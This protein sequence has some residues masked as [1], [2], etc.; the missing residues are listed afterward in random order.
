MITVH[1]SR[2]M[3]V[4]LVAG[5]TIF[6][7]GA[8]LFVYRY[9]TNPIT[10]SVAVGSFN[11]EA[12]RLMTT[13]ASRLASTHAHIRLK[14]IDTGAPL[15]ATEAFASAKTDLAVVRSDTG[16]LSSART[17]LLL[18]YGVAMV[19]VPPGSA[20][21]SIDDL[22]DTTV[23]V[24]GGEI[25]HDL[26]QL[27][28][29]IY[30]LDRA[31]VRFKDLAVPDVQ[32]AVRLKQVNALLVVV[33]MTEQYLAIVRNFFERNPKRKPGLIPI[34]SAEAIANLARAYESFDI[35][36]GTLQGSPP[37][38]DD[39]MT[40]LRVA[41]YLVANKKLSDRVV[42]ELA[43][44]TMEARRDMLGEFP[45]LAQIGAPSTDKD[46]LIPIHPG[47]AAY[48]E[49]T[50]ENLLD[51][52]SN[53]LYLIPMAFG[54]LASVVAAMWKFMEAGENKKIE[55]PLDR[56]YSLARLIRDA[57]SETD[58]TLVEEKID[59]ILEQELARYSK[60]GFEAGDAAALSLAAHRLEHL[61]THRRST[62][63]PSVVELK[64]AKTA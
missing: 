44:V 3:R 27:L 34:E 18:T 36:K 54:A 46:A 64:S 51:T 52:Y 62:F 13:V 15:G 1:L 47:A 56:L 50:E 28:T 43:K 5:M 45:A 17:V 33:P 14:I 42:S 63:A 25:N 60:G 55:T 23:G 9:V 24:V 61:I 39:D 7:V 26:V 29:K 16:D 6:V 20:I 58:V 32:Q 30:D 35:P 10:L 53:A 21:K 4:A 48:F 41:Y 49:G 38:P 57:R 59:N 31:K 40:T 12:A 11:G 19:A 2:W 37:V 8:A 22:K